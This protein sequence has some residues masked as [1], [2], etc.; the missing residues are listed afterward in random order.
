MARLFLMLSIFDW[1][2]QFRGREKRMAIELGK[3]QASVQA[4][5]TTVAL[6]VDEIAKLKTA[7]DP[8]VQAAVDAAQGSVDAAQAALTTA[9]S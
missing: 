7:G 5:T 9:I 6:V 8:A 4:L 2:E 3:L 1:F